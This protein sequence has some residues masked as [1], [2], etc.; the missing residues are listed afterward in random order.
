[1]AAK[2]P[3]EYDDLDRM[4]HSAA[5]LLAAAVMKMFPDAK[6]GVGPVIENG[7]YY[8]MLLPRPLTTD[9]FAKL[10]KTVEAL[11]AENLDF[12]REEMPIDQAIAFFKERG[13]D[14]KV[15]LLTDLQKH[16][17]TNL[18]DEESQ[19]VAPGATASL[20]WTGDFVDLCRGPHV[21]SSGEVGAVKI[22]NVA[23][24]YW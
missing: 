11:K 19:D 23:G 15:E 20:Y 4:R 9:D 22:K 6:L 14:F 12:R 17:T 10:E 16:G 1:M 2:K 5:H 3:A 13:Q 24:A 8:D 21:K 7:F 18:K